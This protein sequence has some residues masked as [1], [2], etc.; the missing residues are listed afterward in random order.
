MI[1]NKLM[2]AMALSLLAIFAT[3]LV[4]NPSVVRKGSLALSLLSPAPQASPHLRSPRADAVGFNGFGTLTPGQ[5]AAREEAYAR[6]V[7]AATK[8]E[9]EAT[10]AKETAVHE[11]QSL[12][13]GCVDMGR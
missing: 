7:R 8:L 4:R 12:D 2:F 1:N 5:L 9:A 10:L 13:E 11:K 3:V 6:S